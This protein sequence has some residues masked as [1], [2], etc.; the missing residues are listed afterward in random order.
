MHDG[1]IRISNQGKDSWKEHTPT[2]QYITK[3]GKA[4]RDHLSVPRRIALLGA[5]SALLSNTIYC[6]YST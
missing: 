2:G 3:I 4:S 6:E 5:W 1:C